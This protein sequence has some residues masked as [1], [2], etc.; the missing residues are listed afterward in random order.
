MDRNRA[1]FA[2]DVHW[3]EAMRDRRV[4][5]RGE[6]GGC[7]VDEAGAGESPNDPVAAAVLPV[8]DGTCEG[9]TGDDRG[10]G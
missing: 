9:H 5:H 8:D 7:G 4:R 1:C 3:I 6:C 2:V 10:G